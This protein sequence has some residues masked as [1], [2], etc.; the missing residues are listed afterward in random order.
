MESNEEDVAHDLD[1]SHARAWIAKPVRVLQEALARA[2]NAETMLEL[3]Q[4]HL[5][6]HD[7]SQFQAVHADI[8]CLT[9]ANRELRAAMAAW[10]LP[11]ATEQLTAELAALRAQVAELS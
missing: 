10:A 9:Q 5:S 7:P 6:L 8:S 1:K 3:T 4:Q 11:A 2:A